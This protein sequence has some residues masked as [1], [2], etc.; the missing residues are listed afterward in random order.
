M[1]KIDYLGTGVC[2]SGPERGFVNFYPQGRMDMFSAL[3]KGKIPVT[4]GV[5]ES[6]DTCDLC[7]KCDKQCYFATGLR[8]LEV[9]KELKSTVKEFLE[10]GG[11]PEKTDTDEFLNKLKEITGDKYSTNDPAVLCAYSNDPCPFSFEK[12]PRYVTVPASEDE[13]SKIVVLCSEYNMP[14]SVRGN[15]SSVMGFVMSEGLVIDMIRM[16]EMKI[17]PENWCVSVGP[18][19]SSFE[20][21][22]EVSKHGFRINAAEPS[23]LVCAN[24]MCSGIFSLFSASYGINADNFVTAKF[25]CRDG[26]SFYMHEHSSPNLYAYEKMDSELPGICVEVKIKLHPVTDDE[27]GFFIPFSSLPEAVKFSKELSVR[28]LGV[29]IGILGG[30]YLSSFISPDTETAKKIRPVLTK[31]LGMKYL[32]LFIGDKYSAAAV[33]SMKKNII[34]NDAFRM[35]FLGLP[36]ITNSELLSMAEEMPSDEDPLIFL[37][38]PG[39]RPLVEAAL[40]PSA[41]NISSLFPEEMRDF[42]TKIYS[43]PEMTDI[44]RL[45]EYRILS[46]RMGREKHVVAFIVYSPMDEKILEEMNEAFARIGDK[47]GIKH[48][49]GFITPLDCGKRAVFEYDYYV[50]HTN[51]KESENMLNAVMETGGMIESFSARFK[52][53]KWIR[54]TL[55]QGFARKEHILY[56]D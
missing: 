43:D 16:K 23:A 30:E 22:K 40:N 19:L 9:M 45:N 34:D 48:D 8:P 46:S 49:Y 31:T 32:V 35:L 14:Y 28:R 33:K 4:E 51:S 54:Y 13:V 17:D 15:G 55:Y 36:S 47:F 27:E 18:G 2:A 42:F 50:D 5:I 25:V 56:T 11:V 7:G 10:N 53:V 37:T 29:A 12:M 38:D 20:V 44:I 52:G 26:R 24:I 6:A 3:A 39:L 21:Q 1:C 41:E